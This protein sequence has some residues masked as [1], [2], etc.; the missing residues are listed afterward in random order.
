MSS[1]A[2]V[3]PEYNTSKGDWKMS[4]KQRI[5]LLGDEHKG[6]MKPKKKPEDP[7][8]P[9]I[10]W[11]PTAGAQGSYN[12]MGFGI[13]QVVHLNGEGQALYDQPLIVESPG[14][15]VICRLG[16]KIGLVQVGRP[17]GPR[18]KGVGSDYVA[19]LDSC[20]QG[21][22]LMAQSMGC[23]LW[24][25][26][27]GL[28]PDLDG[29]NLESLIFGTAKLEAEEEAGFVL[30]RKRIAGQVNANTTFFAH[31][32]YVVES[33]IRRMVEPKPEATES[34]GKVKL[35][36]PTQIRELVT[37]GKL[38]CGLT[39]AALALCGIHF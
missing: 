27:R 19:Q 25:A 28:A 8:V 18:P 17:N 14:S 1:P 23:L 37:E 22:Y 36:T 13:V 29:S 2:H 6:M 11:Q 31:A 35:F 38:V 15:I 3:G 10:G 24:E 7:D 32:Q 21:W 33:E 16:G 34:F 39:L 20:R 9:V 4:E 5:V 12:P 26:P 30:G